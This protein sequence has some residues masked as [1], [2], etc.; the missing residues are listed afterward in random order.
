[1]RGNLSI[2]FPHQGLEDLINEVD[3]STNRLGFAIVIAALITGSALVFQSGLG[4]R[5]VGYPM[6]GLIGF[7]LASVLGLWL[8]VS[9]LRSGRL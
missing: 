1:M 3:R 6:M 8:L 9:I 7:L 5:I 2:G 4:P